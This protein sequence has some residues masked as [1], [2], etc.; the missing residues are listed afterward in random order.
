VLWTVLLIG[1]SLLPTN[2]RANHVPLLQ[3]EHR[4]AEGEDNR[5]T[6]CS[7]VPVA[8]LPDGRVQAITAGHCVTPRANATD[9][10]YLVLTVPP[11]GISAAVAVVVI[12]ND[13]A[14]I[15]FVPTSRIRVFKVRPLIS[16]R[17]RQL[18]T[19]CGIIY[20]EGEP[21]QSACLPGHWAGDMHQWEDRPYHIAVVPIRRGMSG[22]AVFDEYGYVVGIATMG[23]MGGV[24]GVEAI[25]PLLPYIGKEN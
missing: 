19:L 1:L 5:G 25:D 16:P 4:W 14:L 22:G 24:T 3:L 23:M 12:K 2:S 13:I 8:V 7:A 10:E 18:L 11:T 21:E 9:D 20:N 17:A 6:Y 15:V